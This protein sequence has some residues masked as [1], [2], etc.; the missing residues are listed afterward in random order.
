M[1]RKGVS[2][3]HTPEHRFEAR[4]IK[5]PNGCWDWTGPLRGHR[6]AAFMVNG[7]NVMVHRWAYETYVGPIPEDHQID[8][9][10]TNTKCVNPEHLRPM[11][12][13][14][15][16]RAYWREQR[17][18]CRNGHEM[19]PENVVWRQQGKVRH[20]RICSYWRLKRYADKNKLA[21][22]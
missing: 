7:K 15:N 19:T 22:S 18:Y 2:R 8:H 16:V 4:I 3:W 11:L 12:P 9:I 17:G 14:E 1:G 21:D 20:C 13:Y 5:T 6:Y 10:C